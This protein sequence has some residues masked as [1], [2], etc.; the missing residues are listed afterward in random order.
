MNGGKHTTFHLPGFSRTCVVRLVSSGLLPADFFAT[1][2]HDIFLDSTQNLSKSTSNLRP[3]QDET[4]LNET[5]SL[6]LHNLALGDYPQ[7]S[8]AEANQHHADLLEDLAEKSKI[9]EKLESEIDTLRTEL[10]ETR[11]QLDRALQG[12]P[13]SGKSS[14]G[15]S[16]REP[17]KSVHS[18]LEDLSEREN[19]IY[20]KVWVKKSRHL[21]RGH[22]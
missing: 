8:P 21:F 5:P 12:A 2:G 11:D 7:P 15:V 18:L 22:N 16:P 6:S 20:E 1:S 17:K 3:F 14:N 4:K 10:E 19:Q 13:P 9:I